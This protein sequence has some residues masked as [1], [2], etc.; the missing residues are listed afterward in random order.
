MED[1]HHIV[2]L[3][4]FTLKSILI[5]LDL[6]VAQKL[7][8]GALACAAVFQVPFWA[9]FSAAVPACPELS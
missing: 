9:H 8:C 5:Y 4:V 3:A 6:S 2:F 7:Y 1:D